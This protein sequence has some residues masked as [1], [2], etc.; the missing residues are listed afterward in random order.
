MMIKDLNEYKDLKKCKLI[1]DDLMKIQAKLTTS[2]EELKPYAH[3]I[4]VME[5]ISIIHNSRT[6]IEIKISKYKD[7]VEKE[8]K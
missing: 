8:I 5:A 7:I 2:I 4:P 3:Y 6:L 1:Y